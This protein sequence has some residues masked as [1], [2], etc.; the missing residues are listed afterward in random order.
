MKAPGVSA[1]QSG[2]WLQLPVR[3]ELVLCLVEAVFSGYTSTASNHSLQQPMHFFLPSKLLLVQGIRGSKQKT[4][5]SILAM[6]SERDME[7]FTHNLCWQEELEIVVYQTVSSHSP[8]LITSLSTNTF[9]LS[10]G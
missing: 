7:K 8:S 1:M 5:T 10:N 3:A 4:G 6:L 9:K 2:V